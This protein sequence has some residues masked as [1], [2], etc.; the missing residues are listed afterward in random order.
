MFGVQCKRT[1]LVAHTYGS[2]HQMRNQMSSLFNSVASM[3]AGLVVIFLTTP[4]VLAVM[5][6]VGVAYYRTQA[7]APSVCVR[8]HAHVLTRTDAQTNRR[9][10]VNPGHNPTKP[11]WAQMWYRASSREVRRLQSISRSPT[12]Q[13]MTEVLEGLTTVR[14][15]FF[16]AAAPD[17]T[18]LPSRL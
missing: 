6:V 14:R 12:I 2:I 7:S 3:I 16:L 1:W 11:H 9:T 15:E 18:T 10:T 13:H 17:R 4:W 8:T 5:P